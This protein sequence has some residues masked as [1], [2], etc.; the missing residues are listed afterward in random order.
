MMRTVISVGHHAATSRMYRRQTRMPGYIAKAIQ[1]ASCAIWA[2][3]GV[4]ATHMAKHFD[5]RRN[6][7][8]LLAGFCADE[9]QCAAVV[10]A[11]L[12]GLGQ[13]VNDLFAR[14]LGR[15]ALGLSGLALMRRYRDGVCRFLSSVGTL[16]FA[17]I[18]QTAL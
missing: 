3:A 5:L 1:P 12:V 13:I 18:E 11:D 14:K 8:E 16:T 17:F 9:P 6:D 10:R 15:N 7:V 2:G 4:F